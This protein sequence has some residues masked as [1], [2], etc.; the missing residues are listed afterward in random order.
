MPAI[1]T[2]NTQCIG[3]INEHQGWCNARGMTD[4]SNGMLSRHRAIKIIID[5]GA[6]QVLLDQQTAVRNDIAYRLGSTMR[7]QLANGTIETLVGEI[8]RQKSIELGGVFVSMRLPIVKS[9]GVYS[10]LLGRDW[11][12]RVSTT[13]NCK[14]MVYYLR[15]KGR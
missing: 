1:H 11:L 7:I 3:T 10:I 2:C 14:D 12:M 8:I 13:A 4:R 6:T 15:A 9:H 5:P